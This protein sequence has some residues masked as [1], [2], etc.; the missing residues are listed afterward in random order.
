MILS[1]IF[2]RRDDK[3][4][5]G[6]VDRRLDGFLEYLR[7]SNGGSGCVSECGCR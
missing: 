7:T 3:E 5:E 4:V 6:Y 2:L 1:I